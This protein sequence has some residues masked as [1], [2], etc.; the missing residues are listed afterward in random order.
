MTRSDRDSWDLASSVGATATMVAAQRALATAGPDKL[1]DDPFAAPLV[2][3]VGIDFFTRLV[4]GELEFPEGEEFDMMRTGRSMALRTRF[5]DEHFL[6]AT[7][8]GIR[9]AVILAAGLD[10]RPYRLAWPEG[11]VVYE[12]DMP[13]VIDFKTTTLGD[14]GAEPTTERRTVAV[15][16]RDD[17]P[18]A[19]AAA[20]FD[21]SAPTVWSAEGLL[22]YLQPDAQDALFDNIKSLSVPG[23]RLA[24]EFMADLSIFGSPEW[25]A[26]RE[27]LATVGFTVDVG[28][29]IYHGERSHVVEYLSASGWSVSGRTARQLYADAGLEYSDG[30]AGAFGDL[31][32]LSATLAG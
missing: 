23:S 25:R 19:L 1:I 21:A 14:L 22:I 18:A 9:Q 24:C 30:V 11:T 20:G 2:R 32:Y 3:A 8:S 26:R 27:Q 6:A 13:Q 7:H 15:D 5:F 28:D 31:M 29:L 10:S 16:L 12:V 17:W 4:D